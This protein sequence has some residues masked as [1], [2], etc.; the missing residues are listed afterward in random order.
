MAVISRERFVSCRA[1]F[2]KVP[3]GG[4]PLDALLWLVLPCTV[5]CMQPNVP[6]LISR[7][8]HWKVQCMV[9]KVTRER[10]PHRIC[11]VV[12]L[13][14]IMGWLLKIHPNDVA[15]FSVGETIVNIDVTLLILDA[16]TKPQLR[17]KWFRPYECEIKS[18]VLN[19]QPPED[20]AS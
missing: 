5:L 14:P 12:P 20:T 10:P 4:M 18:H 3:Q 8:P 15:Y 17:R 2:I 7:C 11:V 19:C 9:L 6:I 13:D 1:P 16:K